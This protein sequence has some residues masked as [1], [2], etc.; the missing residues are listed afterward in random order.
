MAVTFV[1]EPFLAPHCEL[2]TRAFEALI[3]ISDW[4]GRLNCT[5]CEHPLPVVAVKVYKP[6][7][8]LVRLGSSVTKSV[9][10]PIF[11]HVKDKLLPRKIKLVIEPLLAPQPLGVIITFVLSII[12]VLF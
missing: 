4:S 11:D 2:V 8:A 3:T 10:S 7:L 1:M 9:V 6:A 12:S 5:V